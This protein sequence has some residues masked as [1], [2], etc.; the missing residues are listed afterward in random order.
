MSFYSKSLIPFVALSTFFLAACGDQGSH[1]SAGSTQIPDEPGAAIETIARELAAG[2]GG[3]L[4]QAMPTSYQ[5]DVNAIAHLAGSKV[6]PEVY[7]KSFG[8]LGRLIEVAD[9]QKEFLLNT[10]LGGPQPA[11]QIERFEAAWPSIVGFVQTITSSA[12]ASSAGLQS[13]D[14]QDFF[15]TTV[16]ELIQYTEELSS[17]SDGALPL[18]AYKGVTVKNLESNE[19]T[20][21]LEMTAPSGEVE[22]EVFTRV[23]GRWV[24]ADMATGWESS[25]AAAKAQLDSMTPE[26]VAQSKPQILQVIGM[27]DGVITQIEAAQTQEQFDQALQG[28]MMPLMGLM[29]MQQGMGG[30]QSAPVMP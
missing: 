3:I 14:G 5:I 21:T 1:A 22:T 16:S 15:G 6:D 29:M 23:D 19:H 2:N 13:F 8:L 4:W 12:I 10:K 20:A 9:Q 24:P 18:S 28:A 26:Q 30:G 17:L 27:L 11:D 25:I 7:D